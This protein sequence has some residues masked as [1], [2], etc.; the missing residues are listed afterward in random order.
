MMRRGPDNQSMTSHC[1]DIKGSNNLGIPRPK[2]KK[3]PRLIGE[4]EDGRPIPLQVVPPTSDSPLQPEEETMQMVVYEEKQN[5]NSHKGEAIETKPNKRDNMH[6]SQNEENIG[7]K[8]QTYRDDAIGTQYDASVVGRKIM[9][10]D[11]IEGEK[12]I[13]LNNAENVIDETPSGNNTPIVS[14]D[15]NTVANILRGLREA[16]KRQL[17]ADEMD[18]MSD[19]SKKMRSLRKGVPT[20][21]VRKELIF[22]DQLDEESDDDVGA[23]ENPKHEI[24]LEEIERAT[25]RRNAAKKEKIKIQGEPKKKNKKG[26]ANSNSAKKTWSMT[27][28]DGEDSTDNDKI[29]SNEGSDR[30]SDDNLYAYRISKR[31]SKGNL[32]ENDDRT[33][34]E[35]RRVVHDVADAPLEG[36]VLDF[37]DTGILSMMDNAKRYWVRLVREFVCCLSDK[38]DEDG[39]E[40]YQ[41]VKLRGHT[42][43]FN[44][45]VT[46]SYYGIS[47]SEMAASTLSLRYL[48]LHKAP[49][50]CLVLGSNNTN[51]SHLME[52][53]LYVLGSDEQLNIGQVIFDQVIDHAKSHSTLKPIGFSC[54][55][56]DILLAQ[57]PDLLQPEDGV[58]IDVTPLMIS[59]KLMKGKRVMDVP[60]NPQDAPEPEPT[61]APA[62]EA[63]AILIKVFEEE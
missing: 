26:C 49:L 47:N 9:E 13:P 14:D 6:A 19:S 20:R 4:T 18:T 32:K 59:E 16:K 54:M 38:I 31:K 51:V 52:K 10:E 39:H 53:V 43:D 40:A 37:E 22:K 44:P 7:S 57:K 15:T 11:S 45:R 63:A 33:R 23:E 34:I 62:S 55:I 12:D 28:P 41:K 60:L 42:F 27:M 1:I 5:P 56:C 2:R 50:S 58:G 17:N 30:E 25:E 48:V 35:N 46:N 3:V 24:D 8:P 29:M 21:H 61:L 36:I